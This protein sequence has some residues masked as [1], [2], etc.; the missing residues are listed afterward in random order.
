MKFPQNFDDYL[1]PIASVGAVTAVAWT[2]R[3]AL[4]LANVTLVYSLVV[5]II[6]IRRGTQ[7]ALLTAFISFLCFNFFFIPPYYDFHIADPHEFFDLCVFL[8][9]ATLTGQLGARARQKAEDADQ[10]AREQEILYRLAGSFNQVTTQAEVFDTLTD[11]MKSDMDARATY[12][13]PYAPVAET[14]DM[15]VKYLLLQTGEQIFGTLCVAFAHPIPTEQER[16]L[17]A[18]AAQAAMALHRIEL[19]EQA[20]KSREYEEADRLKTAILRSLSHDLRTPITIIKSSAS[21]LR[22][23][24]GQF[25]APE[26]VEVAATIENEADHL[27]MLIGHLLDLS[28]LQ[29]GAL[30]LNKALNSIEEVAGDVAA[31]AFQL[32][33]KERVQLGL[34]DLPLVSFDYGLMLQ[35]LT[36]LVDNALRYEPS[37]RK[38]ELRGSVHNREVWIAVINHGENLPHAERELVMEPFYRGKDGHIGLGLPIAKGIV[39]AHGGKIWIEDTPGGGTTF[40]VS[41]P[42]A[43]ESIA[44]EPQS[45]DR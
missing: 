43:K 13:L 18:C 7:P 26:R 8:I 30:K 14:P 10:R 21:N 34:D 32:T 41:L 39:E 17:K 23:L 12:I 29:A 28:R 33:G 42:Y 11:V 40:I 38:I 5:L 27:N 37:D 22:T 2:L 4:D 36:N 44:L 35:V 3:G 16:L 6:A 20:Q 1:I 45:P 15:T 19:M 31:R 9:A 24:D 25:S